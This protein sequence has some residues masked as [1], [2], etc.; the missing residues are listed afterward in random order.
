MVGW[1]MRG[2]GEGILMPA[3][4]DKRTGR[5]RYRKWVTL[6]NGTR[7]R[8]TGT[9]ATDTKKAAEDAERKH[10]ERAMTPGRVVPVSK[11]QQEVPTIRDF[12]SRFMLEYLP[13]QKPTE[14]KSKERILDGQLL[15]F[16]GHLRIDEIQQSHVNAYVAAL[17]VAAKT[18]NNRLGVLSTLLGYAATCKLIEDT[19]LVLHVSGVSPEVFA[20]PSSDVQRLLAETTDRRYFVAILLAAEAGLRIGE[21]RG[22]QWTD[23]KNARLTVRRAIDTLNNVGPPKHDKIRT[24]ALSPALVRELAALPRRGLWVVGRKDGDMI[25]YWAMLEALNAIY[26]RAGVDVPTSETGVTMPWHSL[27]HAFGTELAGRGVPLPTIQELMGHADIKTT[28]RYVTVNESQ[29]DEAIA[30]TFGQQAGNETAESDQ[31]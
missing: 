5:W 3:Y 13:R 24:V 22:L 14:R 17:K 30:R 16:F 21:I 26:V 11:P 9:P 20:V 8:I 18:I 6:P 27:R 28:M 10:V 25:G 29:M 7:D 23:V 31:D 1:I 15:P 12:S 4:R 2:R 19:D